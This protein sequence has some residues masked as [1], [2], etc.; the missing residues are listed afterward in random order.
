MPHKT[1]KKTA[2]W[3]KNPRD[4]GQPPESAIV[5]SAPKTRWVRRKVSGFA[6]KKKI[7]AE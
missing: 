3:K 4:V 2:V 5:K 6:I 1:R 7:S